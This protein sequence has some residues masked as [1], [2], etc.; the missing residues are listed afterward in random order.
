MRKRPIWVAWF[1]LAIFIVSV[2]VMGALMAA[3]GS[4]QQEPLA[5]TVALLLA[6]T[7]FM[8]VG[9]LIVAHRPGN[10]IG[11]IFSAV[12]L[13]AVTG[14][15]ASEYADYAYLDPARLAARC[16][17]G[18]LVHLVG[19]VP[20]AGS[21]AAC[22]RCCCSPPAGC[23]R[24]GGGLSPWLGGAA[25]AAFTAPGRPQ[26]LAW[27]GGGPRVL[28]PIGLAGLQDPEES[29]LGV[30]LLDAAGGLWWCRR[31]SRW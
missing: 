5:D 22:S 24:P 20:D 28:N 6:F 7:A 10:A 8:V 25:M 31:S 11:W 12:G 13:L 21:G 17:P 2:T 14:A 3:N 29:A 26:V 15:L 4:F 30:V 18:G 1:M 19:V 23:C 16:G 9:A 27:G